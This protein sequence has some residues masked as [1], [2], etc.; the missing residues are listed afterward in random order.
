MLISCNASSHLCKEVEK[1]D[2]NKGFVFVI[3]R[4]GSHKTMKHDDG[5]HTT[6][7]WRNDDDEKRIH[8]IRGWLQQCVYEHEDRNRLLHHILS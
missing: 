3:Y 5:R 1:G 4:G 7:V 2:A 6:K 8:I